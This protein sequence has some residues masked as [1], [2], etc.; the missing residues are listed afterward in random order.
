MIQLTYLAIIPVI[1]LLL[2]IYKKDKHPEPSSMLIKI[3]GLGCATII[4]AII[5][6]LIAEHAFAGLDRENLFILLIIVFLTVG[7]IEEFFK[8]LVIKVFCYNAE[9]FD[10]PYDAIV[11]AVFSSLGFACIENILYVLT[12]QHSFVTGILRAVTAIPGHACFGVIMGYYFSMAKLKKDQKE[13]DMPYLIFSL[14]MPAFIH[15]LYDYFIMSGNGL[16]IIIWVIFLIAL[17]IISFILVWKVSKLEQQFQTKK[18]QKANKIEE[19]K[20][21]TNCGAE[22]N[23]RFCS[24]CGHKNQE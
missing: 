17:F 12:S 18:N 21:C 3:F 22:C 2:F 1:A 23:T 24:E 15:T 11:Y 10:E 9:D 5:V 16:L 14:A 4:P 20:Y 6:E 13:N 19:K 7:I 8:W